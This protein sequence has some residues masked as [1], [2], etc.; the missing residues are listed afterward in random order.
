MKRL[1]VY[2]IAVYLITTATA[3]SAQ[4]TNNPALFSAFPSTINCS[5]TELARAFNMAEG[6]SISLSFSA[7]FVF[8]GGV[9]SNIQQYNNLQTAV[10]RSPFY[11][12]AVFNLSRITNP[13]QSI[14]YTGHIVNIAYSDGFTLKKDVTGNYQLQ[15]FET[16]RLYAN[17]T[18]L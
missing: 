16:A 10:I 18:K 6:Q 15:K 12:N 7:G 4:G 2:V 1:Y 17:C 8:P 3:G 5:E 11:N 9:I 14:T 13:D